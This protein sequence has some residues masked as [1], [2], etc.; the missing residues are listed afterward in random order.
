MKLNR[1][2]VVLLLLSLYAEASDVG[3]VQLHNSGSEEA[4]ADFLHGLAQ[5]HNFEFWSAADDFKRAQAIDSDFALAYWGEAMTYNHPIWMEQ[6]LEAGRKALQKLGKNK[7]AQLGKAKTALEKDLIRAVQILYGEGEKKAR[8]FLY[9]DHLAMMYEKYPGNP[10]VGA[11]YAL[12]LMGTAHGGRDFTIYMKA[13]AVATALIAE[14][15]EHP[16]LVHYLIHA[17]DDPVHA[18]LG[19]NAA[20]AYS[21]I[22]PSAAHAQHMTSH[23]FLAL[24]CWQAT[25]DAND[26]AVAVVDRQRAARGQPSVGCG[27]YPSWQMYAY[28]QQGRLDEATTRMKLCHQRTSESDGSDRELS[29]FYY[30][31]E[32]YLVETED[33]Q[34]EIAALRV[35][36]R[37]AGS[38]DFSRLYLDAVQALQSNGSKQEELTSNAINA[39]NM[40][41]ASLADEE[42]YLDTHAETRTRVKI[43]HLKAKLADGKREN[44]QA[45]NYWRAAV[46]L[47]SGLPFGFGPPFPAKPSLEAFG[48]FL[49]ENNRYD[50]A[51]D[52]LRQALA[53]TL[54]RTR[55]KRGLMLAVQGLENSEEF[56][57]SR[58]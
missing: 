30:M 52:V 33:R 20:L 24:G 18:P 9:R 5:L 29:G 25:A 17:T 55:T 21:A 54:N 2:L 31:K 47:E 16:G 11:F 53:R 40:F 56:A 22:A 50:E 7:K 6:D 34:G 38:S 8:D 26:T 49:L 37:G 13:A 4:Q 46:E 28:L 51:A 45:E 12:S 1:L 19:Y 15:D 32:L 43:L 23:I 48:E 10:E 39:G 42:T 27:H 14:Y 57:D 35:D 44:Q 36:Q 58:K 3:K 41:I